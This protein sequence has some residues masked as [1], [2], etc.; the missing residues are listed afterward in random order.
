MDIN[1]KSSCFLVFAVITEVSL[2]RLKSHSVSCRSFAL[3]SFNVRLVLDLDCKYK[4]I[5]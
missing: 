5:I 3:F 4:I 1:D 2:P